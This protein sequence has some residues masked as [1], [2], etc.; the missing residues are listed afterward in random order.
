MRGRTTGTEQAKMKNHLRN[1]GR[2]ATGRVQ[3]ALRG[4]SKG[5]SAQWGGDRIYEAGTR[6]GGPVER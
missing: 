1:L 2:L 3:C 6:S 5:R 4:G